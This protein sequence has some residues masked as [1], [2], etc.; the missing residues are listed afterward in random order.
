MLPILSL[1]PM[2]Y[3]VNIKIW[4]DEDWSPTSLN[5]KI[6]KLEI[7][8]R[9]TALRF[10][11]FSYSTSSNVEA[12][13]IHIF[14]I[15]FKDYEAVMLPWFSTIVYLILKKRNLQ[16]TRKILEYK[17]IAKPLRTFDP[18]ARNSWTCNDKHIQHQEKSTLMFML[19]KTKKS[20]IP[21]WQQCKSTVWKEEWPKTQV[22]KV[23]KIVWN[24]MK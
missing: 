8:I 20:I 24:T 18:N 16:I 11:H 4:H 21:F 23:I 7:K 10:D 1:N 17:Q 12:I 22:M 19:N 3:F 9:I 13:V 2:K 6:T 15:S 5:D 14:V